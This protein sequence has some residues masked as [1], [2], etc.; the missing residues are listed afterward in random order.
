MEK[1]SV[2]KSTKTNKKAKR[3]KEYEEYCI[4]EEKL[5]QEC[6]LAGKYWY[7][8]RFFP[9]ID[10]ISDPILKINK[11]LTLAV[12]YHHINGVIEFLDQGGDPNYIR[13]SPV[14]EESYQPTT[15]LKLVV[16]RISDCMLTN[17]DLDD[18]GIIAKLLLDAGA[19][20]IPA[21]ELLNHRYGQFD[22]NAILDNENDIK[23]CN[24][25]SQIFNY[26]NNNVNDSK[27]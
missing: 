20:P 19:D 16:F 11:K 21:M 22:Q 15:P 5:N 12:C 14:Q 24:V 17:S 23:F 18:Y 3:L 8:I 7:K 4:K 27:I 10:K 2:N 25:L 6:L 1:I 13:D 9:E 26:K